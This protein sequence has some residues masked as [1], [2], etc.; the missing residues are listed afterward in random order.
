M[1]GDHIINDEDEVVISTEEPLVFKDD[2]HH[3][4]LLR[5]LNMMRRNRTFCDVIL[6]VRNFI[7]FSSL[8]A[9]IRVLPFALRLKLS[10]TVYPVYYVLKNWKVTVW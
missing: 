5:S 2:N 6:H 7:T 4:Q 1:N 3:S 9:V 10:W 8:R